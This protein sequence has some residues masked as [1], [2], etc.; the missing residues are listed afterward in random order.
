MRPADFR[1]LTHR[2]RSVSRP[3][4]GTA[5][6]RCVREKIVRAFLIE[7]VKHMKKLM[8]AKEKK[9]SSKDKKKNKKKNKNKK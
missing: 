3:Y 6:H 4:G 9:T 7:E 2:Q 5:C 8:A 1:K